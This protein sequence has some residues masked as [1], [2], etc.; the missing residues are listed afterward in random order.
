MCY[1]PVMKIPIQTKILPITANT[2]ETAGTVL[3]NGGIAAFP[4]DTVYGLGA[5]FS[6]DAAVAR[7]FEAKG[8]EEGKPLSILVGSIAQVELLAADIPE[9]AMALMR[10]YWPGALTIIL[11]K[12]PEVSD[13]I[14]AGKDTVGIRMPDHPV[15][16]ALLKAAQSPLAAPSANTSGKRSSVTAED[17]KEDLAGKIDLL[18]DGGACPVGI[19]STVVDLSGKEPV[20]LRE[21]IIT[22]TMIDEA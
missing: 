14:S 3:R 19:S 10:K 15:T 18:L 9:K 7:L 12:R 21:G 22:K 8:R 4:T 2:I 16:L 6:N 11:K 1:N 13:R 5:V 17:V 20:I